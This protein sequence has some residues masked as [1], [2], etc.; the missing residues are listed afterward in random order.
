MYPHSRTVIWSIP[1]DND[2]AAIYPGSLLDAPGSNDNVWLASGRIHK[3]TVDSPRVVEPRID[4]WDFCTTDGAPAA[5]VERYLLDAGSSKVALFGSGTPTFEAGSIPEGA[6]GIQA[7]IA[8]N[9]RKV[10]SAPGY[11]TEDPAGTPIVHRRAIQL[12]PEALCVCGM[13]IHVV[14]STAGAM[15]VSVSYTPHSSGGY[16]KKAS[17]AAYERPLAG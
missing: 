15:E 1:A 10:W 13:V 17:A 3:I 12:F 2:G 8:S 7:F 14:G 16:R 4:I 11:D 6:S 9:C 5:D